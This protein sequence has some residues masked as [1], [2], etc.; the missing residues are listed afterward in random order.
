MTNYPDHNLPYLHRSMLG[1]SYYRHRNAKLAS[2]SEEGK[3]ACE[4]TDLNIINAF[5]TNR[6]RGHD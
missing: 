5:V 6:R 4:R 1:R 2:I 3:A